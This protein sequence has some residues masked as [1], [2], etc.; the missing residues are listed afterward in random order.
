MRSETSSRRGRF[1]A[2]VAAAL[3]LAGGLAL[4]GAGFSSCTPTHDAQR[5]QTAASQLLAPV[6]P[7]PNTPVRPQMRSAATQTGPKSA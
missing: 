3:L 2:S 7:D 6:F 5:G 4:I 1:I